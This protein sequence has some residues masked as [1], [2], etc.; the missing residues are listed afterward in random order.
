MAR[1]TKR[2][3]KDLEKY[4]DSLDDHKAEHLCSRCSHSRKNGVYRF[5]SRGPDRWKIKTV[6]ISKIFL[7]GI[8]ARINS[9]LS[10][11]G[12]LLK[13]I[14]KDKGISKHSEL[15]KWGDIHPRSLS[16]IAHKM[17]GKY[18]IIDGNHRAIKLACSG[19]KKFKLIFYRI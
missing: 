12:W 10:R 9:Y 6:D 13:N 1:V 5:I 19:E 7:G 4:V 11:N 3:I 16:L 18:K 2:T 17:R 15:K 8:N 14:A